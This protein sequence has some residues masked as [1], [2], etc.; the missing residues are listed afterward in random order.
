[1]TLTLRRWLL[2]ANIAA[3]AKIVGASALLTPERG[4]LRDLGAH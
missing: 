4:T 1:M 3:S 2:D